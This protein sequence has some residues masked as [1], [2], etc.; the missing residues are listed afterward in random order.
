[1]K[2]RYCLDIEEINRLVGICF[3]VE[4]ALVQNNIRWRINALH[5]L[6]EVTDFLNDMVPPQYQRYGR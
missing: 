3:E 2:N 6:A 5:R 1:V 4:Q